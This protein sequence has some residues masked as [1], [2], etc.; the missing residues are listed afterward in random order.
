VETYSALWGSHGAAR[1]WIGAVVLT[2]AA[3]WQASARIRTEAPMLVL[4]AVLT[5]ACVAVAMRFV[6]HPVPGRG[7]TIETMAGVWTVLM[8]LGLGAGPIAIRLWRG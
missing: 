6:R 4:L 7:K 1:A 3:A 5:V 2:G 8:Y